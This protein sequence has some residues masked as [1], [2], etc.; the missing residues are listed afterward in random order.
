MNKLQK[1]AWINLVGVTVCTPLAIMFIYLMARSNAKGFGYLLIC[2]IVGSLSGLTLFLLFRKKGLEA[3]F[4]EREKAIHKRSF[5]WSAYALAVF[6]ACVCIIPFFA[7]GGGSDIPIFYLP[8]IFFC[9]LF[10]A[11]FVHSAAVL[12][13]CQLE[14]EDER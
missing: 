2:L 13:L 4:D 12:I 11:Q 5:I 8:V 14:D 9:T 7:L 6:L 10:F 1:S 3:G